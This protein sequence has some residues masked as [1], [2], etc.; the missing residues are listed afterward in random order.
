MG[1]ADVHSGAQSDE[2]CGLTQDYMFKY[3]TLPLVRRT[4]GWRYGLR[5]FAGKSGGRYIASGFVFERYARSL[6]RD[7]ACF[8]VVVTTLRFG[9]LYNGGA[10]V[11]SL[12]EVA[13]K[14]YRELYYRLK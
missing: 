4:G 10:M 11:V 8:C 14:S 1:G 3:G 2:P 7:S 5:Q 13:A 9:G 12:A 6:L